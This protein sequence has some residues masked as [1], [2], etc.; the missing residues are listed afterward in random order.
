MLLSPKYKQSSLEIIKYIKDTEYLHFLSELNKNPCKE[1][2]EKVKKHIYI[3]ALI[4][5]TYL[6]GSITIHSNT[7]KLIFNHNLLPI[8]LIINETENIKMRGFDTS[9]SDWFSNYYEEL[10]QSN[11]TDIYKYQIWDCDL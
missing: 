4:Q 6:S 8:R 3:Q 7:A 2:T 10:E 5:E 9:F 11:V 1:L